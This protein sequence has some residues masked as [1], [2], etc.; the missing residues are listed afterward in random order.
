MFAGLFFLISF[1]SFSLGDQSIAQT[2]LDIPKLNSIV[3]DGNPSDWSGRGLMV[4]IMADPE[5]PDLRKPEDF[6]PQFRLAWD[7][8]GLLV[9]VMVRDD[10][11]IEHAV[12]RRFNRKD[13]I[14]IHVISPEGKDTSIAFSP[15]CDPRFP[16][17]LRHYVWQ[18][19]TGKADEEL[20]FDAARTINDDGYCVEF[21]L[22]WSDLAATPSVGTILAMQMMISDS[23]VQGVSLR[24]RFVAK[25]SHGARKAGTSAGMYL[26]RLAETASKP[27]QVVALGG[28][29]NLV[30][31]R[32]NIFAT[33]DWIGKE[34]TIRPRSGQP[35]QA[36]FENVNSRA[37][38]TVRL[39]MPPMGQPLGRLEVLSGDNV[40]ATVDMPD[41]DD[42]RIK[43]FIYEEIVFDP[44]VFDGQVLPKC[45]FEKPLWVESILGPYE[46]DITYYD[47]QFNE[48]THAE[49]P[50]RYGAV[51]T[52]T[53]E[54]GRP[55]KRFRTI[56]R[57]SKPLDWWEDRVPKEMPL[58]EQFDVDPLISARH[59]KAI[60]EFLKSR[61][62]DDLHSHADSAVLLAGMHEDNVDAPAITR[63]TDVWAA[64][65]QWWVTLKRKLYGTDKVYTEPFVCPKP[66][67]GKPAPMLREGSLADAGMKA[68]TV[69][70]LDKVMQAWVDEAG[71]PNTVCV[72]RNGI[73]AFHKAYGL[74]DGKPMTVDTPSPLASITKT[75]AGTLVMTFVGQDLI[76]LDEPIEKYLPSLDGIEVNRSARIRNLFTHT[77]GF[78]D[79]WGDD[80]NDLEES[81]ALCYPRLAVGENYIYDG[82]GNALGGKIMEAISGKALAKIYKD[83]LLDP[84][85]M[86]NTSIRG[87]SWDA[88]STSIDLARMSQ[89][90]LN[91]GAYGKWRYFS[92]E[93]ALAMRPQPMKL[94]LPGESDDSSRMAGIGT[95]PQHSDAL[96]KSTFGHGAASGAVLRIDPDNNLII[97][98]ARDRHGLNY[99]VY[100]KE[101]LQTV[102]E[103]VIDPV[104]S[105]E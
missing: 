105:A 35:L 37:F 3:I 23:D 60:S 61:F 55:F 98:M 39:P 104:T 57:L 53:P 18:G 102:A 68:D 32:I 14:D 52:V 31:T 50:G 87:T 82:T 28:Y 15:G 73:I 86:V 56:Y 25:W 97:V 2:P 16:S 8:K 4:Q 59:G 89:M 63:A 30:R 48:V 29:E 13:C 17:E 47:A 33:E 67:E 34:V 1:S 91:R 79:H 78:W 99:D 51:V 80:E 64:D 83:H 81:V 42:Q 92:E 69:E 66:I 101:F 36:T 62:W 19:K 11:P 103:C 65:R 44:Y 70:K 46:I 93:A 10:V 76:G 22:D 49:T 77:A 96:S 6:D 84:L 43:Q 45:D 5:R 26:V 21:R 58:P 20:A 12:A 95:S 9:L 41:S 24:S 71:V 72:V 88:H 100:C 85:G 38:A 7:D 94:V 90:L 75:M 27:H 54:K 74:R 40:I